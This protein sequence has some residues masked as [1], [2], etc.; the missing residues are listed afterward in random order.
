MKR[1]PEVYGEL[2]LLL[3]ILSI[4]V[5]DVAVV[6]IGLRKCGRR[7][8]KYIKSRK[9]EISLFVYFCRLVLNFPSKTNVYFQEKVFLKVMLGSHY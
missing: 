2:Q 8:D 5:A 4:R 6:R 7:R 3:N 9:F 1:L